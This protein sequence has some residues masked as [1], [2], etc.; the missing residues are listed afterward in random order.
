MKENEVMA[1]MEYCASENEKSFNLNKA[2]EEAVEFQEVLIKLQTKS[3]E[4]RPPLGEAI[5]EYGDLAF[6]GMIALKTLF[7]EASYDDLTDRVTE[8][9]LYKLTKLKGYK[10]E[11]KYKGGL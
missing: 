11:A 8:H 2:L 7:P 4:K 10:D 3:P 1:I 9:I 5:K 6:R